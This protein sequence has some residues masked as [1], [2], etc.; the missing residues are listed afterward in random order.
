M[1]VLIG[2]E[3]SGRVRDAFRK[4]GHD[5]WSCD[6]KPTETPGPHIMV[7]LLAVLNDGWD[8][9]IAHPE[10]TYLCSS[11]LHWNGRVPGRAEKTEWAL[12]FVKVLMA[13]PIDRIAIENP[14]GKIGTRVRPADQYIQPYEFGDNASKTTGLWLKNL[15]LLKSTCY[16]PP[17]RIVNGKPRWANQCDGGQDK[18][19]PSPDRAA[20][21]ARTYAGIAEA[22]A[23]QWGSGVVLPVQLSMFQAT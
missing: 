13:A 21:R 16:V 19:P 6:L 18:L 10:C 9:M 23:D 1:R 15:P 14:V 2:C 22:M 20:D 4:R 17:A 3:C 7:D 11:G 5:A 8:L 12:E